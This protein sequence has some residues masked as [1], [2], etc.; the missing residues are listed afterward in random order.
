M[1]G[2]DLLAAPA[3]AESDRRPQFSG[4][5]L[6]GAAP[7]RGTTSS[8]RWESQGDSRLG[9]KLSFEESVWMMV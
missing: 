8:C 4:M 7:R 2:A 6:D 1:D 3:R 5:L 9:P